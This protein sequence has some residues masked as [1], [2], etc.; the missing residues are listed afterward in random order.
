MLVAVRKMRQRG[1]K[2]GRL[3][4]ANARP[5]VGDLTLSSTHYRSGNVPSLSLQERGN[6]TA[7]GHLAVLYEP[8]LVGLIGEG[9]RFR[10]VEAVDGTGYAQEWLVDLVTP[11]G[12]VTAGRSASPTPPPR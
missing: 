4:V 11:G 9:M 1:R 3:D 10:G 5:L 7:D 12:E 8:Q 6:Q 2:L